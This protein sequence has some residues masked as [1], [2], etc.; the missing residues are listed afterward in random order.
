MKDEGVLD[1]Q[2]PKVFPD[3]SFEFDFYDPEVDTSRPAS[4]RFRCGV[5]HLSA[6]R[7]GYLCLPKGIHGSDAAI[8]SILSL[9]NIAR[10]RNSFL[11]EFRILFSSRFFS[12]EVALPAFEQVLFLRKKA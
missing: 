10:K 9:H 5:R 2:S 6:R 4:P 8:M 3:N 7:S 11:V 1:L 12:R